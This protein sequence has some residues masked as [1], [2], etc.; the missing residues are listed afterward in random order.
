MNLPNQ[1]FR[2]RYRELDKFTKAYIQ[3]LNRLKTD[4]GIADDRTS[5]VVI[6]VSLQLCLLVYLDYKMPPEVASM[7]YLT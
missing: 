2:T 4:S 6:P 1:E 3:R 7:L 5:V